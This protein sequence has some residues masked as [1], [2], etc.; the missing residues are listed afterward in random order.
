[1]LP[2]EIDQNQNRNQEHFKKAKSRKFDEEIFIKKNE[3]GD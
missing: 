2:M 3:Y 1:M